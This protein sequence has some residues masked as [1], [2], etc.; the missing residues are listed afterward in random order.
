MQQSGPYLG[1]IH[2]LLQELFVLQPGS[3]LGLLKPYWRV[4]T[5]QSQHHCSLLSWDW[6]LVVCLQNPLQLANQ[7]L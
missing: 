6:D 1:V 3:P 2:E 7:G 4:H 5:L